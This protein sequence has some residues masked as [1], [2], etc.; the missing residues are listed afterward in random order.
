[1]VKGLE[2]PARGLQIGRVVWIV[3]TIAV[4]DPSYSSVVMMGT[5]D[6][7][8]RRRLT[9]PCRQGVMWVGRLGI[10]RVGAVLGNMALSWQRVAI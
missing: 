2:V 3:V 9:N 4:M 10:A 5:S 6:P 8:S 1:M 7:S